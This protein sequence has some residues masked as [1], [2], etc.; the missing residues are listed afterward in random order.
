MYVSIRHWNS[1]WVYKFNENIKCF[2]KMSTSFSLK[3][4]NDENNRNKTISVCFY[5][6]LNK[7]Q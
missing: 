2:S 4:N 7:I 6:L 5:S 1:E 3:K